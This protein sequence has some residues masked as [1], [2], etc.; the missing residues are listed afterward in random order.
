MKT[1]LKK[2]LE[3]H[4]PYWLLAVALL[5]HVAMMGSLFWG[6]LD[7]WFDNTHSLPQGIDFFSV[8]EAGN[9]VL[10]Y[11]S[12]YHFDQS[13][14][15]V[16]PHHNPF[17][18]LP[19][20]AYAVA[21]PLNALSAWPAYWGWVALNELLLVMCV[22]LTW[23]AAGRGPW[24]LVAA[25]M[26]LAFTPYYV[27]LYLGQF[28]FLMAALLLL[29]GLG[30]ARGRELLAGVPWAV[31]VVT[32]STSALLLPVFARVGW[33]RPVVFAG[34]LVVANAPYYVG[35]V[36]DLHYFL[37][38]NLGQVFGGGLGFFDYE[39]RPGE[40]RFV[41]DPDQRFLQFSS[42]EHGLLALFRNS[43]LA[44][45][46]SA[47]G[48]PGAVTAAIVALAVSAG[49]VVTFLSR[50]PDALAL[51][52]LWSATFYLIYTAWEHHYVMLLPALTLLVALRPA[53]RPVALGVFA[54][55]ALPSPYWL[56]NAL[57]GASLPADGLPSIQESWSVWQ[58]VVH[59]AVKPFAVAGL[60]VHL[61]IQ[62]ASRLLPRKVVET[63]GL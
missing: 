48:L 4:W 54:L 61:V 21:V 40:M 60:W 59:H 2:T 63:S 53:S 17:R 39:A 55:I 18:Y 10:Q 36:R 56:M 32:K 34:A 3:E 23:R 12:V 9:N 50:K 13:D 29:A 19:I 44:L 57:S 62:Q 47:T 41:L 22:W 46:S 16:T 42:G 8:Y 14:T 25:S 1:F 45:D 28:S 52:C 7:T 27:E 20:V 51:F 43:Y 26:W 5:A 11:R 38:L 49:L 33:W 30:L 31:S 15:S 58:V 6:Y 24:G 35:R 37:W